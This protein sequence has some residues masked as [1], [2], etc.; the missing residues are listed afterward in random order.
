MAN[1][2]Q[3]RQ[4]Q[5]SGIQARRL[6]RPPHNKQRWTIQE[7]RLSRPITKC[8]GIQISKES[9]SISSTSTDL[10]KT[11][12]QQPAQVYCPNNFTTN[13][14]EATTSSNP[15]LLKN[16]RTTV[17]Q[18]RRYMNTATSSCS[19]TPVSKLVSIEL[20]R[21]DELSATNLDPN[22]GVNDGNRR[23]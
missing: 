6:S 2:N 17:Q 22:G 20:S 7:R 13:S 1:D 11:R 5:G 12:A 18:S 19:T 15:K 14:T 4:S 9:G 21:E 23:K 10:T 3:N 8:K 16:R